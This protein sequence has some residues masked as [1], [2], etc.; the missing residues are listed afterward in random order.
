MKLYSDLADWWHLLTPASDYAA[1]AAF[2][3]Q[4]LKNACAPPLRTLL[5][6]GSGG[7][8]NASHLK[9]SFQ[10]TLVDLEPAMLAV[11]R[12]QNPECEHIHGD[13][14]TLQLG[15][16]FDAVFIHDAIDYMTSECELRQAMETAYIHCKPGGAALL[17]PDSISENFKPTTNHEGTDGD[18]RGLRF[19]EWNYDS[20][21]NDSVC[22]VDY[23]IAMR[24][25]DGS[26]RVEHDRHTFGLFPGET[27]LRLL[28]ETGFLPEI[29]D[30]PAGTVV[31][32]A[33]KPA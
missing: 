18:G 27:W 1:E 33:T 7:G 10:M 13:M 24:E 29:L 22:T 14:R 11:S 30:G 31:F 32:V 20:D 28:S 21:P 19:L 26:V 25:R 15:R 3:A 17:A 16:E 9:S 4:A 12:A 2:Y 23:I 5:E 8:N 6:L